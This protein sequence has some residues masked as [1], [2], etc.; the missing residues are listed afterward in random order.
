MQAGFEV[1]TQ[2]DDFVILEKVGEKPTATVYR[3]RQQSTSRE[4]ALKVIKLRGKQIRNTEFKTYFVKEVALLARL[5]HDH[6]VPI[7]AYAV[8]AE[9]A[10]IA[11]RYVKGQSLTIHLK[12]G[13]PFSIEKTMHVIDQVITALIYAFDYGILHAHLKPSNIFLDEAGTIFVSDFAV[14]PKIMRWGLGYDKASGDLSNIGNI[15][16]NLACLTYRSPEQLKSDAAEEYLASSDVFSMGVLL[17]HMLTGRVPFES[18]NLLSLLFMQM[19]R[20]PVPPSEINPHIP[21]AIEAIILKALEKSPSQRYPSIIEMAQALQQITD[22][23]D[24]LDTLTAIKIGIT[25]TNPRKLSAKMSPIIIVTIISVLLLINF[26]LVLGRNDFFVDSTPQIGDVPMIDLILDS[27]SDIADISVTAPILERARTALG[28][29]G[30]IAFMACSQ[31]SEYHS[32]LAREISHYAELQNLTLQIYDA[33]GDIYTQITQIDQ[34]L[35]EGARGFIICPLSPM[36]LEDK[37]YAISDS[38]LP[39]VIFGENDTTHISVSVQEDNNAIGL[40]VGHYAGELIQAELN[41]NANVV[42]MGYP[43]V[44]HIALRGEGMETGVLEIAPSAVISARVLGGARSLGHQSITELLN[45]DIGIDIILSINDIGALGAIDALVEAGIP[46]EDVMIVSVDAETLV[47]QYIENGYY[48]HGSLAVNRMAMAHGLV[49]S[50][51]YLLAGEPVSAL[52]LVPAGD[53]ISSESTSS[54]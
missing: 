10:Y 20:I 8:K 21:I 49:N 54:E 52:I 18:D 3:A 43:D 29:S 27:E 19:E 28:D 16:S 37:L 47:R 45:Q 31:Q 12:E 11:M 6:I 5:Q 22:D 7:Y 48:M 35:T 23:D 14:M 25:R 15:A 41:G 30:F 44:P 40:A 13:N 1:G 50:T 51:L 2:I 46:P 53:I 24:D 17:Y 34:A 4:V 42:I 9:Y 39:L 33:Q 32:G 38:N 36:L 26:G